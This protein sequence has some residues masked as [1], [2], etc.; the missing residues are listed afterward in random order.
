M[1][2]KDERENEKNLKPP[3]WSESVWYIKAHAKEYALGVF[4][5]TNFLENCGN[6]CRIRGI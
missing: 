6:S 4:A 5:Q 1:T 3:Y 2:K